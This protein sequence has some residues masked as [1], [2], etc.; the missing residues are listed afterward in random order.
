M[1]RF[2][3]AVVILTMAGATLYG[4]SAGARELF[5]GTKDRSEKENLEELKDK[6]EHKEIGGGRELFNRNESGKFEENFMAG[7]SVDRVAR[8]PV[9]ADAPAY[10]A[11][12]DPESLK[13]QREITENALKDMRETEKAVDEQN[14]KAYALVQKNIAQQMREE[15]AMSG[16][17]AGIGA[18][19]QSI[20]Q[21][22][23]AAQPKAQVAR[24]KTPASVA[25][26]A[27]ARSVK[28][29]TNP[30]LFNTIED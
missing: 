22:D 14:Q 30:R 23:T 20:G 19:G 2:M 4:A 7:Q 27:E 6:Q 28:E 13:A 26:P 9:Q 25:K 3:I 11:L 8:G 12:L 5:V 15:R 18:F 29:I 17:P 24:A 1:P 10:W 21:P 16:A